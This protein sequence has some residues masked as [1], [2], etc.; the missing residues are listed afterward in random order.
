MLTTMQNSATCSRR[1]L[2]WRWIWF[3]VSLEHWRLRW[4]L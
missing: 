4:S 1:K 3:C 2:Q